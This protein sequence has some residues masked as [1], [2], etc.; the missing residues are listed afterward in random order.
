VALGRWSLVGCALPHLAQGR[1]LR[2]PQLRLGLVPRSLMSCA[3]VSPPPRSPLARK[4]S[5]EL[6]PALLQ[7][8]QQRGVPG[9]PRPWPLLRAAWGASRQGQGPLWPGREQEGLGAAAGDALGRE[10]L[11]AEGGGAL[12]KRAE[13]AKRGLR[14]A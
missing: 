11:G 12:Q 1:G 6:C 14:S 8:E 5:E 3:W 10:I 2:D 13:A 9:A 7:G 4:D